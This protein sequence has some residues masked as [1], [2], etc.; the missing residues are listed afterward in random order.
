MT[1][2][3]GLFDE[4]G[5]PIKVRLVDELRGG[6]RVEDRFG[7]VTRIKLSQATGRA[8]TVGAL[9]SVPQQSVY[10]RIFTRLDKVVRML[11]RAEHV[12]RIGYNIERS[13][14]SMLNFSFVD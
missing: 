9:L 1:I 6:F 14:F 5:N 12:V 2:R 4:F 10:S 3:L 8:G 11:F 7:A 13:I